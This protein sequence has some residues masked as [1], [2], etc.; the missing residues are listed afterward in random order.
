MNRLEIVAAS[1]FNRAVWQTGQ[2]IPTVS[3]DAR[4][5]MCQTGSEKGTQITKII[6]LGDNVEVFARSQNLNGKGIHYTLCKPSVSI[7]TS[8]A[9]QEQWE[10]V[11]KE[12]EDDEQVEELVDL[13]E[14]VWSLNQDVPS[15][16]MLTIVKM[17]LV[18]DVVEVFAVPKPG[19][20]YA[21]N[22]FYLYFQLM[23]FFVQQVRATAALN[24]WMNIQT[25]FARL[26][27]EMDEDEEEEEE[28]ED[29][30]EPLQ[31]SPV[32]PA[33]PPPPPSLPNGAAH[34]PVENQEG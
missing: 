32:M 33:P 5:V 22:G 21:D 19:T 25:E 16:P 14:E 6:L 23:P 24:D 17:V 3:K 26:A 9:R 18:N 15:Q 1:Q 31:A 28:E 13:N 2:P 10:A 12:T 11:M 7:L 30:P 29:E 27:Q 4:G 20:P 8:I 34:E